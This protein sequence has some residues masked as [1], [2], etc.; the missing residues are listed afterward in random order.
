MFSGILPRM[1]RHPDAEAIDRV[2]RDAILNH[3]QISR[4]A[5]SYWRRN[6]VP[7]QHRTTLAM[8]G[9]VAGHDMPE[10]RMMRDRC[11]ADA[12]RIAS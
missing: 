3:F 2:G 8:L 4:Q 6:G 11:P 5:L 12:E 9:A 7:K 10:M 1:S